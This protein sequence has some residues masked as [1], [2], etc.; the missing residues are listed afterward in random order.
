MV[1]NKGFHA[2]YCAWIACMALLGKEAPLSRAGEPGGSGACCDPTTVTCT[3]A[4]A[5]VCSTTGRDYGGDGVPCREC[6]TDSGISGAP[7]V[8]N[9]DCISCS[10]GPSRGATCSSNA[11]CAGAGM[12]FCVGGLNDSGPCVTAAECP[13][14]ACVLSQCAGSC[15]GTWGCACTGDIVPPFSPTGLPDFSDLSAALN[16]ANGSPADCSR[17]DVNCDGVVDH[18]DFGVVLR[19]FTGQEGGCEIPTGACCRPDDS[20]VH[21]QQFVCDG[22]PGVP[23]QLVGVYQG[24]G[25]VCTPELCSAPSCGDGV[26]NQPT[27]ECDGA[28]DAACAA[29]ESCTAGCVCAC[30]CDVDVDDDGQVTSLDIARVNDCL[31][32]TTPPSQCGREDFDCNGTVDSCDLIIANRALAGDPDPC[33][34][35][36]GACCLP[37]DGCFYGTLTQCQASDGGFLG[38]GSSCNPCDMGCPCDADVNDDGQVTQLDVDMTTNCASGVTPPIQCFD[39]NVN[40]DTATDYCDVA[41]VIRAL[42]GHSDP[43][44]VPCGGCCLPDNQCVYAEQTYCETVLGGTFASENSC[45]GVVCAIA[46]PEIAIDDTCHGGVNDG[47]PC[48]NSNQCGGGICGLTDRCDGGANHLQPCASHADCP[49]GWCGAK[50]A[51]MTIRPTAPFLNVAMGPIQA[52]KVTL[53]DLPEFPN[54]NGE[55][56]WVGPPQSYLEDSGGGTFVGS[57]TQMNP[58]FEDWSTV[59]NLHIFGDAVVPNSTY[60]VR[61]CDMAMNCGTPLTVVTALWGD[62]VPPYGPPSG[63]NFID[64]RTVVDKFMVLPVRLSKTRTQLQPNPPDPNDPVDFRDISAVVAAFRGVKFSDIF[65]GPTGCP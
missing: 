27:E 5:S 49:G 14:G 32:G 23:P 1:T 2:G 40:C 11:A 17:A 41:A 22:G 7:C 55:V 48:T 64:I 4:P 30:A 59:P 51:Y 60:E 21:E 43:C 9:A 57:E 63:L 6:S 44:G 19:Q 56:R 50:S 52:I 61:Q 34:E 53:V 46:P 10:S 54:C 29:N 31:T 58:F 12:S 47:L 37:A 3:I 16:C 18:A 42:Q 39:E 13:G 62:I 65:D 45:F 35:G 15:A 8:E 36:C 28:D 24:N 25:S 26:V 38:N 20:C 33:S